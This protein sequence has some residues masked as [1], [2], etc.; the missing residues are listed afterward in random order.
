MTKSTRIRRS[1]SLCDESTRAF[2]RERAERNRPG[3]GRVYVAQ[4]EDDEAGWKKSESG[5]WLRENW[6]EKTE[7]DVGEWQPT[8]ELE[9]LIREMT[10]LECPDTGPVLEPRE[11]ATEAEVKCALERAEQALT[12]HRER[13]IKHLDP[14]VQRVRELAHRRHAQKEAQRASERE[15]G[16]RAREDKAIEEFKKWVP[17]KD[18]RPI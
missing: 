2:L 16:Q 1:S 12:E 6:I 4:S 5:L 14:S 3:A 11:H 13:V 10:E 8:P 18:S 15:V 9:S 17:P 7:W